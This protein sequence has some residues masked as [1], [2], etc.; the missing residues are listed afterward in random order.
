MEGPNKGGYW[1]SWS[2]NRFSPE[3]IDTS[4]LTHV[5]FAFLSPNEPTFQF[6]IDGPTDKLLRRF[7]TSL[8][9]RNPLV[10]TLLSIGG[11]K[12]DKIMFARMASSQ[13]SRRSCI[14]YIIQVARK[15]Y[16]D[17]LDF[18]WEYPQT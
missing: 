3:D 9:R 4:F 5:Y 11:G 17:G 2:A 15:Y 10:K 1:P 16:F 14:H 6:E 8:N 7:T 18:D 13:G 12:S